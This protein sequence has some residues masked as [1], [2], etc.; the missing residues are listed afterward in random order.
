MLLARCPTVRHWPLALAPTS[1][2]TLSLFPHPQAPVLSH[3][4]QVH[5]NSLPNSEEPHAALRPTSSATPKAC[6]KGD[7]S[8]ILLRNPFSDPDF[9]SHC[10][11]SGPHTH[12][13][14]TPP[15]TLPCILSLSLPV[16]CQLPFI[17]TLVHSLAP[18]PGPFPAGSP[19]ETASTPRGTPNPSSPPDLHRCA[20]LPRQCTA[21]PHLLLA[22]T[23]PRR[24]PFPQLCSFPAL[25][26]SSFLSG[27]PLMPTPTRQPLLPLRS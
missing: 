7:S 4:Q 26:P 15:R 3:A 27:S 19:P 18:D 2:R 6:H 1:P 21:V 5:G 11:C 20:A 16:L 10:F 24:Q 23:D 12:C 17:S 9:L 25:R 13:P 14:L 8:E 22:K